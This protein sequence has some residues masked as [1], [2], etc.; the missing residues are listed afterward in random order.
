MSDHN[1]FWTPA[2]QINSDDF[3]SGFI[4]INVSDFDPAAHVEWDGMTTAERA[5][6][7]VKRR[8]RAKG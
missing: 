3:P 1:E 2:V 5:G 4:I 8:G 6:S 7:T